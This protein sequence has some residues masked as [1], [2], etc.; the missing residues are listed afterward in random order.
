MLEPVQ[1]PASA[2]AVTQPPPP[3][4]ATAASRRLT[5][6]LEV[7]AAS[8]LPT[9]FALGAL[10]IGIGVAPFGAGGRLSMTY[11]TALLTADTAALVALIV[12][13]LRAGGERA[14]TLMLGT[15]RWT[16]EA[17]LGVA[18]TPVL[19]GGVAALIAALRWAWPGL[20]NVEANPFETL[21]HSPMN[22]A[23]LMVLVVVS[24]GL[25]EEFQRAFVLHR[26]EQSLG[27]AR[28]GLVLYSAV[29][30][31][32]HMIQ[33]YDVGITTMLMGAAWG[34]VFLWRRSIVAPAVCHA[35]FNAAQIVQ[36][37]VSGV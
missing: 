16:R 24:G 8:G 35:G 4:Q 2:E 21:A 10:L 27:G 13:R 20:H 17:A 7:V 29:F 25:K 19:F 37:V 22:A 30:G 15:A 18:L 14:R 5:A 26:F 1:D 12:W 34:V 32:G 3:P 36:F 6:A 28:V 23:V 31:A 33:G 9:Q 11:V